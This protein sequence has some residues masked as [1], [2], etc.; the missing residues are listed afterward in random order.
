M[1][2]KHKV[3]PALSDEEM[4]DGLMKL[5]HQYDI[6]G[7]GHIDERELWAMLTEVIIASGIGKEG[8]TE[9]DAKTVMAAL[10]EDGNGT[11]EKAELV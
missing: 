7:D 10:D 2:K 4:K 11:V 6:D 8:F 9:E 1:P 5:Y 3:A